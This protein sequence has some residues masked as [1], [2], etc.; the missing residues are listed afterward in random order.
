MDSRTETYSRAD[1]DREGCPHINESICKGRSSHKSQAR[2]E[3]CRVFVGI[4]IGVFFLFLFILILV[5]GF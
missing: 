3:T 1:K 4:V 2:E 5:L